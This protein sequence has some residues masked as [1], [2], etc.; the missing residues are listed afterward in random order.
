MNSAGADKTQIF[1]QH[2]SDDLDK[3]GSDVYISTKTFQRAAVRFNVFANKSHCLSGIEY[4]SVWRG[5]TVVLH[6][7]FLHVDRDKSS[8]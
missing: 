6:D 5:C 4:C 1:L 8:F 2:L 7:P 3:E